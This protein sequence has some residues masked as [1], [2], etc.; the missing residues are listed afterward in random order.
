VSVTG[1]TASKTFTLTG[2]LVANT[3]Y[4]GTVQSTD[5]LGVT[6]IDPYV[7]DTFLTNNLI[8]ECEEYNFSSGLYIDNPLLI[9]EGGSDPNAYNDQFGTE[10][11]DFDD[12]RGNIHGGPTD[13]TF[14]LNDFVKT[15]HTGEPPRAKYVL[16][17]GEPSGY[18][19]QIVGEVA[20]GDWLNF[21]HTY[22]AG[23]YHVYLRQAQ[24][25]IPDTQVTLDRVTSDRTTTDQT[26]V[27]LGS[28]LGKASGW[29]QHRVVPLTDFSGQQL[30]VLRFSGAVDTLRLSDRIANIPDSE[31]MQNYMVFVPVPDPG[32]LRPIVT[33]SSPAAN[34][35][36]G[37]ASPPTSPSATIANRDT[38]VNTN[39]IALSLNGVPTAATVTPIAGGADVTW[40][41][42]N[43]PAAQTITNT[44]SFQDSD[45]VWITN[46]WTYSFA[47]FLSAGNRFPLGS[48]TARGFSAR[49]VQTNG[50]GID[51]TLDVAEQQLAIPPLIPYEVTASNL[52]QTLNP[53]PGLDPGDY[54]NIAVEMFGYLELTA[55]PHRF[56]VTSDDSF[57]LRSGV[58]LADLGAVVLGFRTDGTYDGRFDFMVE[59]TGLYP[60]R[61][62]WQETGGG[63]N[64]FMWSV[65]ADA[66]EPL[67]NDP[68]DPAGVVKAYF[69]G[70][71]VRCL[72]AAT[73]TGP[74]AYE[75]TAALSGVTL[76]SGT[77]TIPMSGA[78]RFYRLEGPR[79]TTILSAVR[80]GSNLLLTYQ[81]Q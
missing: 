3:Y 15:R 42:F 74:Y 17:G 69:T 73:V 78:A 21:T 64:F 18:F 38:T 72:S 25:G 13:H 27:T 48:L 41:F 12:N 35:S 14:R 62:I 8:L 47:S 33:M 16:L 77:V 4:S 45:G 55:G 19:E 31:L 79:A 67:V 30:A 32:T 80:S 66:S 43:L 40:S 56:H 26:T 76:T 57:Q 2:A 44:L 75:A 60:A 23:T 49:M 37:P 52:I 54:V 10:L 65:N 5:N 11:V 20:N 70:Y 34:T 58:T 63:A 22:P 7:F 6:T 81:T 68:G 46:T 59:A 36:V 53:V 61:C 71:P 39:T 51:N 29:D 9:A 28:F 24:Y 1:S 50:P